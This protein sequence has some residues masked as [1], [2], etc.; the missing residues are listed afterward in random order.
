MPTTID[1][2]T[3]VSQVQ[4]GS[5]Q[6]AD[7]ANGA[8]TAPKLSGGQTGN[9]PVY[10]ARAWCV[11]DGT[12][13]GTN[14]PIAGGNVASVTRNGVGDY[15]I[16]FTTAMPDANYCF[17]GSTRAQSAGAV[18]PASIER[19]FSTAKTTSALRIVTKQGASI[20]DV[21]TEISVTILR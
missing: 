15:T 19:E 12:L 16:N 20:A 10:G 3:G 18:S 2:T 5:I 4:D 8:V 17:F 14:T 7:L 21:S 9:A 1:G 6:T 13:T 11:F